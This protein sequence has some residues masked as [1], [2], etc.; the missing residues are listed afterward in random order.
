MYESESASNE[1][2]ARSKYELGS[3]LPGQQIN[4]DNSRLSETT[5]TTERTDSGYLCTL[6]ASD[7]F[8]Y[9][10]TDTDSEI[11]SYSDVEILVRGRDIKPDTGPVV[12]SCR[13]KMCFRKA[14]TYMY[15]DI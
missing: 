7:T 13:E 15:I 3:S 10:A 5:T 8:T 6:T 9:T 14:H 12:G 4:A 1:V 11:L 2:A